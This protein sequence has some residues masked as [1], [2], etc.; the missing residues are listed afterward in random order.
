[1]K[2]FIK[3]SFVTVLLLAVVYAC[4]KDK[5]RNPS[6]AYT[7][8]GLRDSC[9][10][11]AAF[12]YY[13]NDPNIVYPGTNGPHGSFRLKFNH[14]AYAQL[15]DAG[16]LPVGSL[17]SDGS[18][19]VKE[20]LSGGNLVEYA[21]MYKLSGSW[22]WAEFTPDLKTVKHSVDAEHSVCTSCHSQSGNRDLVTTFIFH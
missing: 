13:K 3:L 17:F 22:I 21:L 20:V 14:K 15:T 9:R 16:K 12:V 4:T 19:L 18:M 10:N 8:F 2:L 6:L 7:N 11:T 5:G 1:M